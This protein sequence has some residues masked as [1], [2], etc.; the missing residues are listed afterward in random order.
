M[1]RPPHLLSLLALSL[2][3]MPGSASAT[4]PA[5]SVTAFGNGGQ[6]RF[7]HPVTAVE[8]M[9]DGRIL[10][11][12]DG[13]TGA[14]VRQLL[15]NGA[16]DPSF[17][18]GDGW[19][20]IRSPS[21]DLV[22]RTL[23][24]RRLTDGRIVVLAQTSEFSEARLVLLRL[25]A[26]GAP[27]TSFSSDG[28][29]AVGPYPIYSRDQL[30]VDPNSYRIGVAR[31]IGDTSLLHMYGADGRTDTT[32]GEDGTLT[33]D[34]G[35]AETSTADANWRA[36]GITG[37]AAAPDGTFML[38]ASTQA[39][40]ESCGTKVCTHPGPP[41][42]DRL[43]RFTT[44]GAPDTSFGGSGTVISD[45]PH[46][47]LFYLNQGEGA[48]GQM[49]ALSDG[50]TLVI[51]PGVGGGLEADRY[52]SDGSRDPTYSAD[53]RA[54]ISAAHNSFVEAF[55]GGNPAT[56]DADGRV[57]IA[58]DD[59]LIRLTSSGE[60]DTSFDPGLAWIPDRTAGATSIT[61]IS[62]TAGGAIVWTGSTRRRA[63]DDGP[64][65]GQVGMLVGGNGP[66]LVHQITLARRRCGTT[67]RGACVVRPGR[68]FTVRGGMSPVPA[69]DV[70]RTLTVQ[71][72]DE[73]CGHQL[74]T[75]PLVREINVR[76]DQHGSFALRIANLGKGQRLWSIVV[77]RAPAGDFTDAA[78]R[79]LFAAGP[80]AHCHMVAI[81]V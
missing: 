6:V 4:A 58:I 79:E 10:L 45:A 62:T 34:V 3:L 50:K 69:L 72:Y 64:R 42:H 9:P 32:F 81:P 63:R 1:G 51:H 13:V 11:G 28:M 48:G 31:V 17:G 19:V 16:P 71:V 39:S 26:D 54:S 52:R 5:A 53:G 33:V 40:G 23:A 55:S 59:Q 75:P 7:S 41:R 8:S 37:W 56:V 47:E 68:S 77:R 27:D 73:S 30:V 22:T 65:A 57:L 36:A 24:L 35:A 74:E 80:R 12:I 60:I 25:M 61:A 14:S 15:G 18:G 44:E 38:A 78:A 67:S 29:V 2:L 66:A 46:S 70:D 43:Y 21:G 20:G 49:F 76:I